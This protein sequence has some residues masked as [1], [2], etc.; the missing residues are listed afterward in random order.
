MVSQL[1]TD[2]RSLEKYFRK[3]WTNVKFVREQGPTKPSTRPTTKR[4]TTKRPTTR[5]TTMKNSDESE[6]I[7][8]DKNSTVKSKIIEGYENI[9][10][11]PRFKIPYFVGIHFKNDFTSLAQCGGVLLNRHWILTSESC[12]T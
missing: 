1:C 6:N 11:F 12:I 4:S 5:R 3:Q 10:P 8:A 7:S 9:W 2:I